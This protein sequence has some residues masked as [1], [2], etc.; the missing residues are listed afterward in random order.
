MKTYCALLIG[1]VLS[2]TTQAEMGVQDIDVSISQ[3]Q[4]FERAYEIF[5][6]IGVENTQIV[7]LDNV[8]S[9]SA[10]SNHYFIVCRADNG[11]VF[12]GEQR[13]QY[14]NESLFIKA[15]KRVLAK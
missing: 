2:A 15:A 11:V 6:E 9:V 12:L 4:C 5:V 14:S 8:F 3:A 7:H 10:N 13:V 1:L